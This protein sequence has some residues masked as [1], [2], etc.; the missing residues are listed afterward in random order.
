MARRCQS[1]DGRG[2]FSLVELLVALVFTMIL[3]VGMAT[4]FKASLSTFYTSGEK[5]SSLRRNDMSL[6]LL[7][8]DLNN[9]GMYLTDLA[10]LPSVSSSNQPFQIIP[11]PTTISGVTQGADELYFYMDEP[12]PFEGTLTS[13]ASSV[14][15]ASELVASGDSADSS[16]NYTYTINCKES[17][18]AGQVAVG[19]YFIFKDAWDTGY[20][21]SVTQSG[22][23]VTVVAGE[24]SSSAITGSGATGLPTKAKHITG[25]GVV[26]VKPSQMVKYSVQLLQLDPTSSTGIP[27][28]VRDQGAYSTSGFTADSTLRQIITENVSGFRVYLSV[29]SGR[30]WLGGSAYSSWS[31]IRSALDAQLSTYGRVDYQTTE[32][33]EHWFRFIPTIVRIDVTTR[34]AR[35]R[36]EYSDSTTP[37]LAYKEQT[38]SVIMVPRHFG[39]PFD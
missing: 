35:Q 34:T 26:F 8:D 29:D 14:A 1:L 20:V 22:A 12:L 3:M 2:G 25:S 4:V 7:G 18:Y 11:N 32:N 30:T 10:N 27:C 24:H 21:S 6:D 16:S 13:S 19:Q 28:L 38:Q 15:T 9:A 33:S 37:T 23:S 36:T 5:L 39:L 31:A 17:A